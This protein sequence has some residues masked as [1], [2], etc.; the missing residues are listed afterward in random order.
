MGLG[1]VEGEPAREPAPAHL[2]P[3]REA[4]GERA[5]RRGAEPV[6]V[7]LEGGDEAAAVHGD[8]HVGAGA[9]EADGV[10][11]ELREGDLEP[12]PVDHDLRPVV[13]GVDRHL[14]LA[15][16]VDDLG[17]FERAPDELAEVRG[18]AL[19]ARRAGLELRR[20]GEA[21]REA[22]EPRQRAAAHGDHGLHVVADLGL[23]LV[24]R[25][26]RDPRG[27]EHLVRDAPEEEPPLVGSRF[28]AHVI[29]QVPLGIAGGRTLPSRG[30]SDFDTPPSGF[31]PFIDCQRSSLR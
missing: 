21:P 31:W 28:V 15:T 27:R 17:L 10:A 7:V 5:R 18:D 19:E 14:D 25:T 16:A 13:R 26:P 1:D 6:A 30:G 4:I 8:R 24:E 9:C 3:G 20:H 29:P 11:R 12:P 2:G 22:P 23:D